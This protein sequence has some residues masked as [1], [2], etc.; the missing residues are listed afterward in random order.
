MG[1]TL[2]ES[3][4]ARLAGARL[5]A[6][7]VRLSASPDDLPLLRYLGT[8]LDL[9]RALPLHIDLWEAQNTYFAL[10]RPALSRLSEKTLDPFIELGRKLRIEVP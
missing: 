8:F 3:G 5:N 2:E 9:F 1:V 4:L 6:H 10:Y 7:L